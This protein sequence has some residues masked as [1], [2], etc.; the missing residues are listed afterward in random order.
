MQRCTEIRA[1]ESDAT[2]MRFTVDRTARL[3]EGADVRDRVVHAKSRATALD[4]H[5]L[6][7]VGRTRRVDGHEGEVG[8]ISTGRAV[9]GRWRL[10]S[11]GDRIC[12]CDDVVGK[13]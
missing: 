8:G 12:L 4:E 10:Q 1:V 11:R 3:H 6:V 9:G 5:G 2:A 7:E 13:G